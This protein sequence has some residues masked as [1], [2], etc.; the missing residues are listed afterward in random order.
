MDAFELGARLG[1]IKIAVAADVEEVALDAL[2]AYMEPGTEPAVTDV[3]DDL[4]PE[5][6]Q[7]ERT[8]MFLE[9]RFDVE[10]ADDK[11]AHLFSDGTVGDLVTSFSDQILSKHAYDRSYYRKNR[12]KIIQRQR[13]YR[14]RNMQQLRRKARI[15]RRR[16]KRRAHRPRKRVG[17]RGGGYQFIPR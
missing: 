15:Y 4:A 7:L 5:D 11:L 13:Q 8:I 9:D 1:L 17:T 10:L 6:G 12:Q 3:L 14:M 2:R 16:V